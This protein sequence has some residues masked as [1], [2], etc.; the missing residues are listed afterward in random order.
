MVDELQKIW[1]EITLAESRYYPYIHL[2]GSNKIT[3]HL[4]IMGVL[5]EVRTWLLS[6]KSQSF[7][8]SV[9]SRS[10]VGSE[11]L[12]VGKDI[13]SQLHGRLSLNKLKQ[14]EAHK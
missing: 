7:Y 1:K 11:Y 6:N 5:D 4:R 14:P 10:N 12:D 8:Q 2:V 3:K 9:S 13:V